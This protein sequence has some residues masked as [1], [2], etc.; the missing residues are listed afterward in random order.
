M[1]CEPWQCAEIAA[2]KKATPYTKTRNSSG[3]DKES[4]PPHS[5]GGK[6]RN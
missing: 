6:L 4:R 1:S 5:C 3:S 2:T